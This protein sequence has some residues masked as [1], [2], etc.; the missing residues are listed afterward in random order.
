M[1]ASYPV[2]SCYLSEHIPLQDA[3]QFAGIDPEFLS[4]DVIRYALP[5]RNCI[6]VFSFGA[7]T[8]IGL[9]SEQTDSFI[10]NFTANVSVKRFLKLLW[11]DY[12]LRINS[13]SKIIVKSN[14]VSLPR[15]EEEASLIISR[16]MAQSVAMDH[17]E[18]LADRVFE[19]FSPINRTLMRKGRLAISRKNLLR[20]IGLN[21]VIMQK[22]IS[23]LHILDEPDIVWEDDLMWSLYDRLHSMF[24]LEDRFKTIEYKLRFVQEN[25]Q[26]LLESMQGRRETILELSI[27]ALILIEVLLFVYDLFF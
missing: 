18:Q 19:N 16:I 20:T 9:D 5:N 13:K 22:I 24:D 3:P 10:L 4:R 8:F 21:N 12:E 6:F 17:Y 27:I 25:S 11:E 14:E 7:I 15:F 1:A 26:I 23:K 2:R